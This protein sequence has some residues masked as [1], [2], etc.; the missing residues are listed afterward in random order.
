MSKVTPFLWFNDTA[1]E[2]AKFYVSTFSERGVNSK[3]TLETPMIVE[4]EIDGQEFMAL[5]GGPEFK[6][7]EAVS[8]FVDCKDQNDVDYFWEKLSEGGKKSQCGWLKDKFGLSWQIV[9]SAL[10]KLMSDPDP[11]KSERVMQ[12]ML[13]MSKID[14][15]TLEK[16]YKGE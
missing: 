5:N 4:F 3:I 14:I 16:A 12:A 1:G 6:F 9:P 8:F 13:A 2:A 7:T 11:K 10:G 15:A